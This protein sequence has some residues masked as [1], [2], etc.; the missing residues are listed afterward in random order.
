MASFPCSNAQV[1]HVFSSLKFI[2]SEKRSS[3]KSETLVALIQMKLVL[4]LSSQSAEKIVKTLLSLLA[5]MKAIATDG[6][7]ADLKRHFLKSL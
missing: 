4:K 2:K 7:S 5:Y 6:E 1:E 3:M